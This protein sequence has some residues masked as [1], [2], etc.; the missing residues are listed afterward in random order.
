MWISCIAAC[1]HSLSW[2]CG[3][4]SVS[5][6]PTHS[7]QAVVRAPYP[8]LPFLPALT[9]F[10]SPFCSPVLT[11]LCPPAG[12][13]PVPQPLSL[14]RCPKLGTVLQMQPLQCQRMRLLDCCPQ[15]Y[16]SGEQSSAGLCGP[17]YNLV[18]VPRHVLNCSKSK[19]NCKNCSVAFMQE[20]M[21]TCA[22]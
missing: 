7:H 6:S 16:S 8:P 5:V 3:K 9:A 22:L 1:I 14:L 13:H 21:T 15:Q 4:P 12:L 20:R 10:L 18:V 2:H 19:N 11:N 17:G